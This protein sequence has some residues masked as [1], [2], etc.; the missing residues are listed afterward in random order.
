MWMTLLVLVATLAQGCAAAGAPQGYERQVF[1]AVNR[2]RAGAGL[3]LLAWDEAVARAARAHSERMRD[4]RFF[5]HQ[6]P[7]FGGL[8][9]G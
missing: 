3:R 5:G 4:A 8:P 7:E 6:D 1:D 2:T 9:T